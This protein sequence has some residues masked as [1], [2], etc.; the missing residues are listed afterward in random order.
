MQASIVEQPCA[1]LRFT[2][3]PSLGKLARWLRILG[4]DTCYAAGLSAAQFAALTDSGRMLLTRTRL[5]QDLLAAE[6]VVFIR[7]DDPFRQLTQVL[8][9]LGIQRR[10]VRLFTRCLRCNRPVQALARDAAYTN[11]PDYVWETHTRFS[12]CPQCGGIYW[13]G[14]HRRR[15]LEILEKLF[16]T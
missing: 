8:R 6:G 11:V 13:Q 4:F 14:S 2:A 9:Q 1:E 7:D 10:Q 3:G 15:C 16:V 5:V 12:T